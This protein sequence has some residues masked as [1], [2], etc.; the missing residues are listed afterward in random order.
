MNRP[1]PTLDTLQATVA[2]LLSC[3][4]FILSGDIVSLHLGRHFGHPDFSDVMGI[5]KRMVYEAAVSGDM[6]FFQSL[7]KKTKGGLFLPKSHRVF[8]KKPDGGFRPIDVPAEVKRLFSIYVRYVLE[9]LIEPLLPRGMFGRRSRWVTKACRRRGATTLD[10]MV[11]VVHELINK[12][13]IYALIVDLRDAFGCLPHRVLWTT[14]RGIGLGEQEIRYILRLVRIDS[15]DKNG[16]EYRRIGHG[17]EQGNCLSAMLLNL[18]LAPV[19]ENLQKYRAVAVT[20]YVDDLYLFCKTRE[21]A[22]D[23]FFRFKA[24]TRR[25]GYKNVRRLVEDDG[26]EHD[27]GDKSSRILDVREA[28]LTVLKTYLVAPGYIGLTPEKEQKLRAELPA[29]GP[30]SPRLARRAAGV[31]A[32]TK[33]WLRSAGV[34]HG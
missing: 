5:T 23:A 24:A 6:A 25:L 7:W 16:K 3:A 11:T 29:E 21:D 30:I 32:V 14:L 9:P 27:D 18:G 4:Y 1:M 17:V 13:F 19:F 34:T 31:Q 33:R 8:A 12:G 28:P 15:I 2:G 10:H 20:S 26:A 22:R